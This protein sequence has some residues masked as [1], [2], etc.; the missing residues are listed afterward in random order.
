M[1]RFFYISVQLSVEQREALE[2]RIVQKFKAK[3]CHTL[4]DETTDLVTTEAKSNSKVNN[5]RPSLRIWNIKNLLAELKIKL[6]KRDSHSPEP[7]SGDSQAFINFKDQGLDEQ[8]PIII[9]ETPSR[10]AVKQMFN[11]LNKK[12]RDVL[13]PNAYMTIEDLK[14]GQSSIKY[15]HPIIMESKSKPNNRVVKYNVPFINYDTKYNESPFQTFYER[16][17]CAEEM[18]KK[19]EYLSSLDQSSSRQNTQNANTGTKKFPYCQVCERFYDC[20]IELHRSTDLHKRIAGEDKHYSEI[21]NFFRKM[22]QGE[23]IKIVLDDELTLGKRKRQVEDF[24]SN[25]KVEQT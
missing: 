21:D 7:L 10:L 25:K 13:V 5:Q 2:K 20:D 11:S 9:E 1:T 24:K 3:I 16:E 14:T 15:F 19:S 22:S 4:N 8:H 23:E 6:R 18:R 17:K 12:R